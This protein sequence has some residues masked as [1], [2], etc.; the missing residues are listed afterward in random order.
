VRR[1]YAAKLRERRIAPIVRRPVTSAAFAP[2]TSG[3]VTSGDG[4]SE[5][6][7]SDPVTSGT[8]ASE[9]QLGGQSM[10]RCLRRLRACRCVAFTSLPTGSDQGRASLGESWVRPEPLARPRR[11]GRRRRESTSAGIFGSDTPNGCGSIDLGAHPCFADAPP[12]A[13]TRFVRDLPRISSLLGIGE[14]TG[15]AT[16]PSSQYSLS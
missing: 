9:L 14:Q 15:L 1:R 10:L 6:Q 8:G 12:D 7:R 3:P 11:C 5:L 4:S 2:A 13:R 16:A